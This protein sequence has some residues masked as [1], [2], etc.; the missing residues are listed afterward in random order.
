MKRIVYFFV[1][2]LLS[3]SLVP[4]TVVNSFADGRDSWYVKRNGEHKQPTLDANLRYIEGK[5]TYYIDRNHSDDAEEKVIYL[6]FDA[7]YEN[8]NV[9]KILDVLKEENVRGTF[10]VLDHLIRVN[11]ELVKR[12]ANEGHIVA[13]H[14][15]KHKDMT[16]LSHDEFCAELSGLETLYHDITGNEMGKFYRPPQGVFNSQ[17]LEWASSLGYKTILWSFAYAD[18]DNDKQMSEEKAMKI[19]M[20][21]LHN[22]EI[23]LLHPTSETN[24]KIMR[25]LIRELKA[26][27]YSFHTVDEL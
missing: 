4:L 20:D 2:L 9:E 21:N 16:T 26:M 14:T 3:V 18:W 23:M 1:A 12:M 10:F 5:N 22:G 15:M 19:I 24:A 13:N 25:R 11:T 8:G 17:N 7:G 6:T 27:G